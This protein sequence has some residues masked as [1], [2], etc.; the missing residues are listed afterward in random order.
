MVEIS[1]WEINEIYIGNSKFIYSD[2]FKNV[3][4]ELVTSSK[5]RLTASTDYLYLQNDT[6]DLP[7]WF[8]GITV[9][10]LISVKNCFYGNNID[11]AGINFPERNT[12]FDWNMLS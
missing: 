8:G 5:V 3:P 12:I 4:L 6:F 2:S 7:V 1:L 10:N 11:V 9:N